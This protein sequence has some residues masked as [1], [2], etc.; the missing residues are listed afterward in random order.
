[1]YGMKKNIVD[2][3]EHCIIYD[4]TWVNII[5]YYFKIDNEKNIHIFIYINI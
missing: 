5:Q 3:A 1:M 4:D 2:S